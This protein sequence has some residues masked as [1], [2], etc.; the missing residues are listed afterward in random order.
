MGVIMLLIYILNYYTGKRLNLQ[1][2]TRWLFVNKPIF[3]QNFSHIGVSPLQGGSEGGA[4]FDEESCYT[5]KFY[6]SGR[7]NCD[8][9]LVTLDLKKRQDLLTMLVFNLVWIERDKVII[10][11]IV[12]IF[13]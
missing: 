8:Y 7:V 6:A 10:D 2:L 5:Y 11:V 3:D 1:I 12:W 4:L 13:K 9:C